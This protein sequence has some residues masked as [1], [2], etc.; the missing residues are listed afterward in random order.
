[1]ADCVYQISPDARHVLAAVNPNA[2]C[3]NNREVVARV[4]ERLR[5]ADFEVE[6][7]HDIERLKAAAARRAESGSLRAVIAAGGDGTASLIANETPPGTPLLVIPLGTE[8]LLAKHLGMT[9]DPERLARIVAEGWACRLDAGEANGKLFLVTAGCGFDADVVR[10]M[11]RTRRG[12]IRHYSYAGPIFDAVRH[13]SY[14]ELKVQYLAS[15]D[16]ERW[17]TLTG[18]W[19]FL[20]NVPRYAGG[21]NFAPEASGTDGLIDV[22]V[23]RDGSLWNGL[24]YLSQVLLGRQRSLAGYQCVRTTRLKITTDGEAPYQLD[25]DP[26]GELPL[27]VVVRPSRLTTLVERTWVEKVMTPAL[28]I[29]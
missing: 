21:L 18:R 8:N 2:G 24:Y 1:M 28:A 15:D 7:F 10:R 27:E 25:G 4:E 12:Q 5:E 22:C 23:F 20:V 11:H 9:T 16:P 13:Y 6:I 17:E 29:S 19:V 3:R 26:G 14:P